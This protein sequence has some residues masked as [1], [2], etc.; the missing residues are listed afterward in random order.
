MISTHDDAI[1]AIDAIDAFGRRARD[2]TV[3]VARE[4]ARGRTRDDGDV[5]P[6]IGQGVIQERWMAVAGVRQGDGTDERKGRKGGARGEDGVRELGS[7][8]ASDD[9]GEGGRG[10][11]DGGAGGRTRRGARGKG[12]GR[13]RDDEKN[14]RGGF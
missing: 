3:D 12:E 7:D 10:D 2:G 8:A 14:A 4:D 9:D 1:D 6:E 5:V 11:D 13:E